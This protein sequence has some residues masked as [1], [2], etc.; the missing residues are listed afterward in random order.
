VNRAY[1]SMLNRDP[2]DII[3]RRVEDVI[4][5]EGYNAIRP[6][7]ERALQGEQ[8]E[9]E[10]EVTYRGVG[11]RFMHVAYRPERDGSGNVVGWMGS[12]SDITD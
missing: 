7:I 5:P 8:L 1:A 11:T 2:N 3:G 12:I 4:G 6:Y 9:Y 10:Q